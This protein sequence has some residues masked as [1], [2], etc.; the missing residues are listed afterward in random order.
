M[1]AQM[2]MMGGSAA[3]S[4]F[5]SIMGA[6]ARAAG[7]GE[8]AK[9]LQ[10]QSLLANRQAE[11]QRFDAEVVRNNAYIERIAA[12][13]FDVQKEGIKL[14][15]EEV[16]LQAAQEERQ[17]REAISVLM[18]SNAADFSTR[19]F[20]GGVGTSYDR[21][22]QHNVAEGERDV[23]EIRRVAD[24]RKRYLDFAAKD[25]EIGKEFALINATGTELRAGNIELGAGMT[26]MG[27]AALQS[28]ANATWAQVGPTITAGWLQ[29]GTT[30][31][32]AGYRMFG[33]YASSSGK[34]K[35]TG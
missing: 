30:I 17:R 15:A 22:T 19:G 9:A 21:M 3:L 33:D 13:K 20:E 1:S 18:A 8:Q 35:G 29:A 28:Q 5:G 12:G 6:N 7:I 11:L 32:S 16:Y 4:A 10:F 23:K 14:Q 24:S 31:A 2:A 27:A 34:G 25:A 26:A